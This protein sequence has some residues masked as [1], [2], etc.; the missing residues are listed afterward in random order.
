ML[1]ALL[2]CFYDNESAGARGFLTGI[3][4]LLLVAGV[5]YFFCRNAKK[6]FYAREGLVSVGLSWV[7]LSLFGCIPFFVSGEVP[8]IVD[9]LFETVSGFTTTG[10]S[11]I[12]DVEALPRGLQYWRCFSQWLGGM[13]VLV[14]LLAIVPASGD[15]GFTMHIL[16][17][18]SPGPN[19]GKLVPK[20][21]QTATIL[22]VIYLVLTVANVI[23]LMAGNMGFFDAVCTAFSTAGTGGFGVKNDSMAGYGTYIQNVCTVFM[24]LFG[25]NFSCFYFLLMGHVKEVIKDEELHLYLGIIIAATACIVWNIHGMYDSL[26]KSVHHA[27][28][29]VVS[30]M[31]TTGFATTDYDMWP[32]F[33]KSILIFLMVIGASAGS[34]SG[35][36]KCG[37]AMLLFK[38]LRRNIRQIL[39]PQKVQVVRNNGQ[40]VSEKVLEN[41]NAYLAAYVIIIILSFIVVS[42]DGMSVTT[43]FTSVVAAINNIG[44]GLETVG[45]TQTYANFGVISKLTLIVDMLA[46]RLEIFPILI[47][48]SK[49]TWT[50]R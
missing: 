35:G 13:G 24:L 7:I 25:I 10:S 11:I 49:S 34:T 47:L 1:P 50:R 48:F 9:A 38:S 28:F 44:P 16:R 4:V 41:T 36:L 42:L 22:Y 45:P 43:N 31:T 40:M 12:V 21:R 26:G 8:S 46:G 20:M 6:R 30:I 39:H 5:L 19:V 32:S 23:F 15:T 29:Q 17:A 14:F 2:I 37:R 27:V 3:V 33:S 18:E